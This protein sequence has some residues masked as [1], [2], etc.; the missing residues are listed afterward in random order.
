MVVP[1]IN[2]PV[3]AFKFP[4][5][6]SKKAV[7]ATEFFEMIATLS[8]LFRVKLNSLNNVLPST[9]LLKLETVRI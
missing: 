8:P 1:K 2:S 9:Y 4:F 7:I 5:S 6:I 3:S